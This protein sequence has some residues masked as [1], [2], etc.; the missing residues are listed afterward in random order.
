MPP[1]SEFVPGELKHLVPGNA[2]RLLDPRRT[3]VRVLGCRLETGF[4]SVEVLDFED[5][6]A[7]WDLPVESVGSFQFARGSSEA[8]REEVAAYQGAIERLDLPLQILADPVARENTERRMAATRAEAADWLGQESEFFRSCSALDFST[9]SGPVALRNDL[10]RYMASYGLSEIEE[11]LAK[12]WVSNPYAGEMVKGHGI[13][14]AEL[15]LVAFDGRQLRDPLTLVGDMDKSRRADH[16]V[17]RL[18]F[19]REAFQRL[20]HPTVVL[21]RGSAFPGLP[22]ERA[23][24]S[25]VSATFSLEVAMSLFDDRDPKSTGVLVRQ[26]VPVARLFMSYLETEQMNRQY[27]E[28]E[29]ILLNDFSNELF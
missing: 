29:A 5:R 9:R 6:G 8:S 7:H 3:P 17:R 24:D 21:Y 22:R 28:A 16:I 2:A 18:A 15:G 23:R 14:L 10:K 26:S 20:G 11:A 1:D 19:V 12:Q 27:M 13:V 25:L 4:F